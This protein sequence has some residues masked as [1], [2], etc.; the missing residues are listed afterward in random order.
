[1]KD[2]FK[3]EGKPA[4]PRPRR[5]EA[6]TSFTIQSGPTLC[7]FVIRMGLERVKLMCDC[8]LFIIILFCIIYSKFDKEK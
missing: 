5:P 2:H 6:L 4:P 3:P 1:M 7:V 8:L